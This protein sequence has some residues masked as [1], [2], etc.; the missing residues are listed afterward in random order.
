MVNVVTKLCYN[1]PIDE[2]HKIRKVVDHLHHI[3]KKLEETSIICQQDLENKKS[4]EDC[5]EVNVGALDFVYLEEGYI[6]K[7]EEV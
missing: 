5:T 1:I 3:C 2:G 7:D 4:F 6:S